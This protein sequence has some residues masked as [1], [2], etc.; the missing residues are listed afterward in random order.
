MRLNQILTENFDFELTDDTTDPTS[1]IDISFSDLSPQQ[2]GVLQRME[3]GDLDYDLASDKD[4]DIMD[5][6]RDLGLLDQEWELSREGRACVQLAALGGGSHDLQV[7][8]DA[9]ERRG[10]H[11]TFDIDGSSGAPEEFG[12]EEDEF[13]F[14]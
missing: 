5:E 10:T 4:M 14:K 11:D 9:S 7:A 8:R 12:V 1:S 6:L 3:S 13:D 2:V